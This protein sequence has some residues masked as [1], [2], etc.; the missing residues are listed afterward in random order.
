MPRMLMLAILKLY[1]A[2]AAAVM[3]E[4]FFLLDA[5]KYHCKQLIES[6]CFR[7]LKQWKKEISDALAEGMTTKEF[8]AYLMFDAISAE[9][10]SG[11]HHVYRGV[12]SSNGT[13]LLQD[14]MNTIKQLLSM[15]LVDASKITLLTDEITNLVKEAG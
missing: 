5:N 2:N 3:N 11:S 4:V 10:A 13:I 1:G 8:A 6:E 7:I 14:A 9:L 15:G 12:L